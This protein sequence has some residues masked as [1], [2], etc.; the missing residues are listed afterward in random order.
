M[1]TVVREEPCK[2][3]FHEQCP[4][5]TE[6]KPVCGVDGKTYLNICTLNCAGMNKSWDGPCGV[7]GNYGFIMSQYYQGMTAPANAPPKPQPVPVPRREH[8]RGR[9]SSHKKGF[10]LVMPPINTVPDRSDKLR[11]IVAKQGGNIR[12][13]TLDKVISSLYPNTKVEDP[14]HFK[15]FISKDISTKQKVA[16]NPI[17][18]FVSIDGGETKDSSHRETRVISNGGKFVV[19]KTFPMIP[20]EMKKKV[21]SNPHMYYT[22]FYSMVMKNDATVETLVEDACKIKDI[23]LYICFDIFKIEPKVDSNSQ[24]IFP[25]KAPESYQEGK[26][27]KSEKKIK[28]NINYEESH[29]NMKTTYSTFKVGDSWN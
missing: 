28:L 21:K 23:L 22:Y 18:I 19:D 4:C 6:L 20:S 26:S 27:E 1:I 13:P 8:H 5:N 2:P 11:K 7:I 25:E 12:C 10:L 9:S 16:R 29:K 14:A 17:N 3:I 24:F 15:G